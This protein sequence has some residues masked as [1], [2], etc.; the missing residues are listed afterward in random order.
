M[1]TSL[2]IIKGFTMLTPSHPGFSV[3]YDCIE[4][5]DLTITSAAKLMGISRQA[6]NNV[7]NG[8]A[9]I[10]A[11]MALKF[12]TC[13]GGSAELWLRLQA[14]YDLSLARKRLSLSQEVRA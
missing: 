12:E 3:R 8:K 2:I 5:L 9:A 14:A 7:V 10:T 13:L 4:P 11:D 6:L 1:L